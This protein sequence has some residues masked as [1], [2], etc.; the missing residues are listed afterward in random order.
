VA[1]IVKRHYATNQL[2]SRTQEGSIKNE[3]DQGYSNLDLQ[4]FNLDLD[5]QE[6][7]ETGTNNFTS[8]EQEYIYWHTK[9]GHL[10]KTRMQQ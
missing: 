9:L 5:L 2:T 7:D 1:I 6:E 8:L 10:S 3:D 4:E